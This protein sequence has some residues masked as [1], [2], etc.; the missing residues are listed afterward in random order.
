MV[1]AEEPAPA[2]LHHLVDAAHGA[3]AAAGDD[4]EP[5]QVAVE[6]LGR[7]VGRHED[8]VALP[9]EAGHEAVAVAVPGE[10]AHHAAAPAREEARGR[11]GRRLGERATRAPLAQA[12][13]TAGRLGLGLDVGRT[14]TAALPP[15]RPLL[16][17]VAQLALHLGALPRVE[18]GAVHQLAQGEELAGGAELGEERGAAIVD[19][20]RGHGW[21]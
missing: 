7:L 10:G 3:A 8:V 17:E 15:D 5:H 6:R 20:G 16:H 9:V 4:G 2:P 18:P 11:G 14:V 1:G 12:G 19:A 13:L 21:L